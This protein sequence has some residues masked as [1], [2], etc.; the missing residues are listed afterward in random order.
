MSHP[1]PNMD[2]LPILLDLEVDDPTRKDAESCPR[3]AAILEAHSAFILAEPQPGSNPDEAM[4]KLSFVL[5][6]T[7]TPAAPMPEMEDDEVETPSFN[8]LRWLLQPRIAMAAAAVAVVIAAVAVFNGDRGAV[9]IERSVKPSGAITI[10]SAAIAEDGSLVVRWTALSR[11]HEY[12]VAIYDASLETIAALEPVTGTELII[13]PDFLPPL[14]AG[15]IYVR[16]RVL[17][18]EDVVDISPPRAVELR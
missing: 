17:R 7:L 14:S 12:Q 9:P 16:V 3:C 13:S 2:D 15:L 18:D 10:E 11:A 5:R 6:E 4:R 1:C 8:P